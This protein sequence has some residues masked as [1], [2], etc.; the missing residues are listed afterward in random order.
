MAKIKQTQPTSTEPNPTPPMDYLMDT[1]TTAA[2]LGISPLT[3]VDFRCKGV[4]PDVV[5]V[6]RCCR[7]RRSAIEAWIESRTRK[8]G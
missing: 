5:R 8:G 7:Y 1:Q 3:L 2:F 4:G 6:G